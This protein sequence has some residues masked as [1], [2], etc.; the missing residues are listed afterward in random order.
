[1]TI[2]TEQ[3]WHEMNQQ[4]RGFF[5]RRVGDDQ[6]AEDLLQET[7]L[8]IHNGLVS[9]EDRERL[10][11]WVYRIAR[12]TLVDY[13]RK[14]TTAREIPTEDL[15]LIEK[16]FEETANE[17]VARWLGQMVQRL[18]AK[19]QA[20][21]E[22]AEFKGI[23]QREVSE[24]LGISLSGAK[25]RVQRGREQLKDLLVQCCRWELDRQGGVVDYQP[26]TPCPVCGSATATPSSC[27]SQSTSADESRSQ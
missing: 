14:G 26:R 20:A 23:S 17:D 7:F 8:R 1:M 3:T 6:L 4:L 13:L 18:P 27:M 21:V 5:R 22:L 2:S 9:L 19:Y 12:N 11:A 16:P 25:S 15:T 24:R 10:G